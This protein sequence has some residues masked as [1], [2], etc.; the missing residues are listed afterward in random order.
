[1]NES[2][3]M[4][5][6]RKLSTARRDHYNFYVAPF[7]LYLKPK[8]SKNHVALSEL[9]VSV[10]ESL[11]RILYLP[12]P[13]TFVFCDNLMLMTN[14]VVS[15][16]LFRILSFVLDMDPKASKNIRALCERCPAAFHHEAWYGMK[17][18]SDCKPS[19]S[20]VTKSSSGAYTVE[21]STLYREGK[22][23]LVHDIVMYEKIDKLPWKTEAE[24]RN[25]GFPFCILKPNFVRYLLEMEINAEVEQP[26]FNFGKSETRSLMNLNSPANFDIDVVRSMVVDYQ[27]KEG[28]LSLPSY[29]SLKTDIVN[30]MNSYFVHLTMSRQLYGLKT[31]HVLDVKE[32]SQLLMQMNSCFFD[33]KI[34]KDEDEIDE[35]EEMLEI[36]D[37][38]SST[39][40]RSRKRKHANRRNKQSAD[41]KKSKRI[42]LNVFKTWEEDP[43]HNMATDSTCFPWP[44]NFG[45]TL[46]KNELH[47]GDSF[48]TYSG[49]SFSLREMAI[50]WNEC[51]QF[52]I[53]DFLA[54][55]YFNLCSESLSEFVYVVKW[56]AHI[57]QM[58]FKKTGVALA[59]V[60]APG[61]GK[62]MLN[63]FITHALGAT[64]I[65]HVP[66]SKINTDFNTHLMN[67][68]FVYLDE[69]KIQ[70]DDFNRLKTY[71]T[72]D[73][74]VDHAKNKTPKLSKNFSNFSLTTNINEYIQGLEAADRRFAFSMC[75]ETA[76]PENKTI[77]NYIQEK[78]DASRKSDWSLYKALSWFFVNIDLSDFVPSNYVKNDK[79]S[80]LMRR[81]H[82]NLVMFW[83]CTCINR[84]SNSTSQRL[85]RLYKSV[86]ILDH[87]RKLTDHSAFGIDMTITAE[88]QRD[89]DRGACEDPVK[90]YYMSTIQVLT[91]AEFMNSKT[92][93]GKQPFLDP[94]MFPNQDPHGNHDPLSFYDKDNK[95]WFYVMPTSVLYN[96]FIHWMETTKHSNMQ[97]S[98]NITLMDFHCEMKKLLPQHSRPAIVNVFAKH[99]KKLDPVVD[100]Q[101]SVAVAESFEYSIECFLIPNAATCKNHM[102]TT[103]PETKGWFDN[104]PQQQSARDKIDSEFRQ[105][106]ETWKYDL[107]RETNPKTRLSGDTI[108]IPGMY[109]LMDVFKMRVNNPSSKSWGFGNSRIKECLDSRMKTYEEHMKQ[110]G[111]WNSIVCDIADGT[112]TRD[113]LNPEEERTYLD[114]Y[115]I[116]MKEIIED[117]QNIMEN[118]FSIPYVSKDDFWAFFGESDTIYS[119]RESEMAA[120]AE[121]EDAPAPTSDEFKKLKERY[122]KLVEKYR[123]AKKELKETKNRLQDSQPQTPQT[124]DV[125]SP[126][127]EPPAQN[128]LTEETLSSIEDY[129]SEHTS[130]LLQDPLLVEAF[131]NHDCIFD[132][133]Y[134]DV[135][136]DNNNK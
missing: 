71:I 93:G 49:L 43:T 123:T 8:V 103:H 76:K 70:Q 65:F 68:I 99:T 27:K 55:I 90:E 13:V 64:N 28:C 34:E 102:F 62:G 72:E 6:G 74:A 2:Y 100:G 29:I 15:T 10:C 9:L 119:F 21:H 114:M 132:D 128:L 12:N 54:V 41:N 120:S 22:E 45:S 47:L 26:F 80:Q 127:T 116:K 87:T 104:L 118:W 37:A 61:I 32:R 44:M 50:A 136:N 24:K 130:P 33:L 67:K 88:G 105:K 113:T 115:T 91:I 39:D 17:K 82:H 11:E 81:N 42:R 16:P 53:L 98:K 3:G 133:T 30:Y 60:G 125:S 84:S 101:P 51:D 117:M 89:R 79:F 59:F 18:H 35:E 36:E 73:T 66:A 5:L 97:S 57:L 122:E 124:S 75:V 23:V 1:M 96:Y 20:I 56:I 135:D 40:R 112:K 109:D 107:F 83:W 77:L 95:N 85:E 111:T 121:D 108:N 14:V 38:R 58:P 46:L 134:F 4:D 86:P 129:S 94:T 63:T 48:N 25:F 31:K 110:I 69:C 52:D 78:L 106:C 7:R 126:P 92:N 131:K 19:R